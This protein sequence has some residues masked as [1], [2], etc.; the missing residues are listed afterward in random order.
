MKVDV[1]IYLQTAGH[2]RYTPSYNPV[3]GSM[4]YLAGTNNEGNGKVS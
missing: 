3:V 2:T 1:R 4:V